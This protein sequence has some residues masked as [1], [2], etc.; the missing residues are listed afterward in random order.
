VNTNDDNEDVSLASLPNVGSLAPT[1]S[2]RRLLTLAGGSTGFM[3]VATGSGCGDPTSE[4]P[5]GPVG[6]GN[7][8]ALSVG[9]MLVLSNVVLGRDAGG[10][11]AMSAVCTHQG[12]LLGGKRT[13]VTGLSC[14]CH[15]SAFDGNGR[16]TRGPAARSLQHYA[17]T[18]AADGT[19][20]VDGSQLVS[21][22]T[23]TPA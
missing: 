3:V 18:I 15:G 2:R 6:A 19:I 7:V 22:T 23:R 11:Y 12:C 8:S 17:V 4:P 5:S 1:L 20:T 10:V 16:V 21:D 13:V 14:P 9:T